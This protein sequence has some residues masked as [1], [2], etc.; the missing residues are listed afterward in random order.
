MFIL[1]NVLG[2]ASL[3]GHIIIISYKLVSKTIW[4]HINMSL[5]C[6]NFNLIL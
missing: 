1:T 2:S 5:Q 4:Q 3:E 6:V